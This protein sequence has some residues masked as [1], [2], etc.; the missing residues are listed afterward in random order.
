VTRILKRQQDLSEPPTFRPPPLIRPS[1]GKG[2]HH[3]PALPGL[4][5]SPQGSATPAV[6]PNHIPN[7]AAGRDH[8]RRPGQGSRR[9]PPSAIRSDQAVGSAFSSFY[10]KV[11]DNMSS[12]SFR[13]TS[14][15]P[16][17]ST[18]PL[19]RS[20]SSG[21]SSTS[22]TL[23]ANNVRNAAQDRI[24]ESRSRFSQR[25]KLF[26]DPFESFEYHIG[27]QCLHS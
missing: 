7:S 9:S 24:C 13:T 4:V 16:Q 17:E 12:S 20:G 25:C 5:A 3:S 8:I 27:R 18:P 10:K 19:S 26:G 15:G 2:R 11:K 22:G 14:L 1:Q 6:N 23:P 21:V